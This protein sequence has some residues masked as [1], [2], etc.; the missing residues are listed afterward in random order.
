MVSRLAARRGPAVLA[1]VDA[2]TDSVGDLGI[3]GPDACLPEDDPC[4]R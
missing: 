3:H 1:T 2:L 4:K